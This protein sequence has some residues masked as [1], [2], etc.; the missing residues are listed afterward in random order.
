MLCS[1]LGSN[2]KGTFSPQETQHKVCA[3]LNYSFA[4]VKSN[5]CESPSALFTPDLQVLTELNKLP[6]ER[7]WSEAN[8]R[9]L[10][11][12]VST[13]EWLWVNC[14]KTPGSLNEARQYVPRWL[15]D[16][17]LGEH[18]KWVQW[19]VGFYREKHANPG[20]T[21]RPPGRQC[22]SVLPPCCCCPVV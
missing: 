13:L 1:I 8:W 12:Q 15:P 20:Q 4:F 18:V 14:S 21:S 9:W 3:L 11:T 2:K 5:N 10:G 7:R 16:I 22:C 19:L 17:G 6:T